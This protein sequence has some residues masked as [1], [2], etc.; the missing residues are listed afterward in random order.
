MIN[1]GDTGKRLVRVEIN[2]CRLSGTLTAETSLTVTQD[3][4]VAGDTVLI[5]DEEILLGAESPALTFAC[6]RAQNGTLA[7][8]HV[9][10]TYVLKATGATLYSHTFL[11][12]EYENLLWLTAFAEAR[13]R[14]TM[15]E[16]DASI[17]Y[18]W[19]QTTPYVLTLPVPMRRR[20]PGAGA[21]L[22]VEA[23]TEYSQDN[24]SA[25][26]QS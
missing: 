3:C 7:T 5:G 15:T 10:G 4:F 9:D 11:A 26:L 8:T 23:W 25:H 1:T 18:L 12:G 19:V 22:L 20:A 6:T 17:S 21:T 2:A 13:F 16:T 14:I 24:M